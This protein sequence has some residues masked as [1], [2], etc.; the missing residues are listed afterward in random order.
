MVVRR[1]MKPKFLGTAAL[2]SLTALI[3]C[4]ESDEQARHCTLEADLS[5]GA[6]QHVTEDSAVSCGAGYGPGTIE[7]GFTTHESGPVRRFIFRLPKP[8]A[9]EGGNAVAIQLRLL[10]S[11]TDYEVPGWLAEQCSL[12]VDDVRG[13]QDQGAATIAYVSAHGTCA[14]PAEPDPGNQAQALVVASFRFTGIAGWNN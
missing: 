5:G 12:I 1:T 13:Q 9:E 14:A 2:I 10:P 8:P 7:I 11:S 3:A 4:G 6:A